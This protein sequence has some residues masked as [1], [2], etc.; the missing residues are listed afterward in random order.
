VRDIEIRVLREVVDAVEARLREREARGHWI[1]TPRAHVHAA[2]IHAFMV[3]ARETGHYGAGSLAG[4]PLLDAILGG[5]DGTDWDTAVF[6]S[7]LDAITLN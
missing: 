2:V 6:A 4:A 7:L 1:R 5:V 3:S